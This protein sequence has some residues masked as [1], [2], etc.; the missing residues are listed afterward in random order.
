MRR[1]VQLIADYEPGELAFAEQLQ[2]LEL[3]VPDC[4]VNATFVDPGDTLAAGLCVAQLALAHGPP[5]WMV[6]HDV[7]SGERLCAGRT[8]A[9][10]VVVGPDAGWSW[11]FVV[12]ELSEL[13]YLDVGSR[14]VRRP[15]RDLIALA[16]RHAVARH[17]H[18]V[19]E[20]VPRDS[21]PRVPACA[22]AWIDRAGNLTTTLSRPPAEAG[23]H[24]RVDIGTARGT[25]LVV[26]DREAVPEGELALAP[27]SIGWPRR[28][29]SRRRLLE[30]GVQGGSAAEL[31]DHPPTGAPV[32]FA[33]LRPRA[34]A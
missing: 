9:G 15:V 31:F 21:M 4:V 8:H 19:A 13:F 24:V 12:D 2:R 22:I 7:G 18:A 34:A 28:D 25:A 10:A 11:S 17:P 30:L 33:P 20:L 26:A 27:S 6:V 14:D 23:E 1:L 5:G 16:V 3:S 32:A 29:G